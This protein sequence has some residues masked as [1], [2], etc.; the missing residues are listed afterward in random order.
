M[1]GNA[2]DEESGGAGSTRQAED[3]LRAESG[4]VILLFPVATMHSKVYPCL[5]NSTMGKTWRQSVLGL[6]SLL[7][8]T[9]S[10]LL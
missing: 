7:P 10:Q 8:N 2:E 1:H 9:S 5:I 6:W 4:Y 3:G